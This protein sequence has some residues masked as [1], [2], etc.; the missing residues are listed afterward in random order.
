MFAKDPGVSHWATK[1]SCLPK[2]RVER[3]S[4]PPFFEGIRSL[5]IQLRTELVVGVHVFI[6]HNSQI[7]ILKKRSFS[8]VF[9][10][11]LLLYLLST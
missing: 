2:R 6:N 11:I 4:N 1:H 9:R 8:Q 10:Q 5:I 7:N 3:G